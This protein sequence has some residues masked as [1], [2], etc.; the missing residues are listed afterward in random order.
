MALLVEICIN[1][2]VN[3][4]RGCDYHS[5]CVFYCQKSSSSYWTWQNNLMVEICDS[6][7]SADASLTDQA[8]EQLL[9]M[10]VL[11]FAALLKNAQEQTLESLLAL[12]FTFGVS[13]FRGSI[14]VDAICPTS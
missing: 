2:G 6:K 11:Q 9:Q 10:T 3:I 1:K 5:L 13:C 12:E 4:N 14:R 7:N 8:T